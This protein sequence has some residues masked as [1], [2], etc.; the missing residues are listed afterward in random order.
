MAGICQ[1]NFVYILL[2]QLAE[3][4]RQYIQTCRTC[5]LKARVTYRDRVPIKPILRADRVFDHWFVDCAGPFFSG[6]ARKSSTITRS[7]QSIVSADFWFVT[8]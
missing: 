1:S 6:E 3:D 2:A 4:C 5:Q 7:L 8:R